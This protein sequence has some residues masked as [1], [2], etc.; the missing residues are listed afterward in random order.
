M[1]L[2]CFAG[3]KIQPLNEAGVPVTDLLVQRG[4]GIFDFLRTYGNKPFRLNDHLDRLFN[5]AKLLDISIP[6][7]KKEITQIISKGI[8]KNNFKETNIKIVVTGGISED[9]TGFQFVGFILRLFFFA[10]GLGQ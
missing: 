3:N 1:S 7:S 8:D 2:F 10:F 9:G 4:Y 6:K 5:S